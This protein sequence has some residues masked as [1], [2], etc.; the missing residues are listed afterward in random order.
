VIANVSD[1]AWANA[2]NILAMDESGQPYLVEPF[3]VVVQT[4]GPPPGDI[5]ELTGAPQQVIL[6]G[7]K[8][9]TIYSYDGTSWHVVRK[10][11]DPSYP[12]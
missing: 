10:G 1:V 2:V 9:G 12:G 3:G 7:T 5:T 4:G 6:A 11:L 8:A